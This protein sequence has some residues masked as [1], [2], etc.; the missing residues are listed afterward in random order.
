MDLILGTVLPPII[1]IINTK[2]TN[3]RAKFWIAIGMSTVVGVAFNLSELDYNDPSKF[4]ASVLTVIVTAQAVYKKLYEDS[5]M[6][7]KVQTTVNRV[8]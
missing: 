3:D 8:I 7:D 5:K 2:V 4:L 1:D 6:Q